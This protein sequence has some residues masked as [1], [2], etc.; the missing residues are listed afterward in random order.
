MRNTVL[1][2]I[3]FYRWLIGPMLGPHCRFHPSCSAFAREAV[4]RHGVAYGLWLTAGRL[5]RCQ[6]FSAGGY[7]PVPERRVLRG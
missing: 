2:L 6:P 1:K 4:A 5:L 3:D 7:D